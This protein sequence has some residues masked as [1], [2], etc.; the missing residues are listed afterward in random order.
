MFEI[1]FSKIFKGLMA[2]KKKI[3]LGKFWNNNNN[4]KIIALGKF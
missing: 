3:A 2:K 4:S 1:E